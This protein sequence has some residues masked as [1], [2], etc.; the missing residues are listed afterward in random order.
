MKKVRIE[1]FWNRVPNG[2][3]AEIGE[4]ALPDTTSVTEEDFKAKTWA[5]LREIYREAGVDAVLDFIEED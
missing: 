3:Y 4:A 5:F 1:V 2:F